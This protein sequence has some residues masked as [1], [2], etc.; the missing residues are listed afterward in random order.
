MSE[1]SKPRTLEEV[2]QEFSSLCARA[3]Q[4]QYQKSCI[5]KDLEM[6]NEEIR[7]L[8]VEAFQLQEKAKAEVV[9]E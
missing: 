4:A 5:E 1:A 7:K 6:F 3:G 8:N 2:N 9:S